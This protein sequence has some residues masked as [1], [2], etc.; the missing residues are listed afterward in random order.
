MESNAENT[1]EYAPHTGVDPTGLRTVYICLLIFL[2]CSFGWFIRADNLLREELFSKLNSDMSEALSQNGVSTDITLPAKLLTRGTVFT[3]SREAEAALAQRLIG[4]AKSIDVGGGILRSTN[5][6]GMVET[7]ADGAFEIVLP[8]YNSAAKLSLMDSAEELLAKMDLDTDDNRLS[9]KYKE[10]EERVLTYDIY[11]DGL[12]IFNLGVTFDFGVSEGV[13]ITG[14]YPLGD[15]TPGPAALY[16]NP[17]TAL[18]TFLRRI[19]TDG[20][21]VREL[22]DIR[23]GYNYADN[24]LTPAWEVASDTLTVVIG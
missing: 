10:S 22:N 18:M 24:S 3:R 4:S 21:L 7:R 16:P 8:H 17:Q 23:G 1:I 14:N 13:R 12:P 9:A 15:G 6:D 20:A 5:S 2:C 11:R 19:E